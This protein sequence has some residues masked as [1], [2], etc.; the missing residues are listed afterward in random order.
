MTRAPTYPIHRNRRNSISIRFSVRSIRFSR[1]GP[2]AAR[3]SPS[4]LARAQR[5]GDTLP[6]SRARV[7]GRAALHRDSTTRRAGAGGGGR[8]L[9]GGAGKRGPPGDG[10]GP[11]PCEK[12]RASRLPVYTRR[13]SGRL[14]GLALAPRRK[15]KGPGPPGRK[16]R[17][18]PKA[19]LMALGSALR[20][21][22]SLSSRSLALQYFR[23]RRA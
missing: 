17:G 1:C 7:K 8:P 6:P 12:G 2:R 22:G 20:E 10:R 21:R 4:R 16:R 23:R 11:P 18:R 13:G 5:Q 15:R 14:D 3:P 9:V 19:A